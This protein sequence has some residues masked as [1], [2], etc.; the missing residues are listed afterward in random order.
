M[1]CQFDISQRFIL[2]L[3]AEDSAFALI[4]RFF[5]AC[6]SAALEDRS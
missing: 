3:G 6:E 5:V 2:Q 1:V 4:R